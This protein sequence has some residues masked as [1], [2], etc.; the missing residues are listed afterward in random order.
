MDT[1]DLKKYLAE[2]KIN[3]GKEPQSEYEIQVYEKNINTYYSY[4]TLNKDLIDELRED[5]DYKH[6]W[7]E[8]QQQIKND[9]FDESE[10]VEAWIEAGNG[11]DESDSDVSSGVYF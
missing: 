10:F 3:E 8:V 9:T 5:S 1:F 4:I 6:S 2:G 7:E 11:M